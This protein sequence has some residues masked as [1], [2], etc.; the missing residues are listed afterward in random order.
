MQMQVV[1]VLKARLNK[2]NRGRDTR[3]QKF[4]DLLSDS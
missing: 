2:F 1:Q 3:Q 4:V